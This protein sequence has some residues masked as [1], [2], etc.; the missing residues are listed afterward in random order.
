MKKLLG[1]RP[2]GLLLSR[3]SKMI[4]PKSFKNLKITALSL[5]IMRNISKQ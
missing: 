1:S 4:M 5:R 2:I 3:E